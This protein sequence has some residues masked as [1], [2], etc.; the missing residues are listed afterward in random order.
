MMAN[1]Q[2]EDLIKFVSEAWTRVS[3]NWKMGVKIQWK[4]DFLISRRSWRTVAARL[5]FS[6]N[7]YLN[8]RRPPSGTTVIIA[9]HR[10]Q[11]F[12]E[13][14]IITITWTAVPRT[15]CRRGRIPTT[16]PPPPP[17]QPPS[18]H[19]SNRRRTRRR[20]RQR[21]DMSCSWSLCPSSLRFH[22]TSTNI[23][24]LE[25]YFTFTVLYRGINLFKGHSQGGFTVL[26]WFQD[27]QESLNRCTVRAIIT[28]PNVFWNRTDTD[29]H[30]YN[31]LFIFSFSSN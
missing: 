26:L 25:L 13:T 20:R 11:D 23:C 14:K 27:V 4:T 1:G 21:I 17:H 7:S 19:R 31:C 16:R 22:S 24:I 2:H 8:R 3:G 6:T 30:L 5:R 28:S 15:R 12:P 18:D 29:P 10:L 9:M